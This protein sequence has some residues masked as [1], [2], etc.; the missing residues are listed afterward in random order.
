MAD[1]LPVVQITW[2]DHHGKDGHESSGT[3]SDIVRRAVDPCVFQTTGLLIH[4]DDREYI[5]AR[6]MRSDAD[7]VESVYENYLCI[8]KPLVTRITRYQELR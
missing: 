6:D 8:Q 1:T 3:L 7:M 5:V 4:E 2:I